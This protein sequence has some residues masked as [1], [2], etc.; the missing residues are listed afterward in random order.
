MSW[1]RGSLG[2]MVDAL[3][4]EGSGRCDVRTGAVALSAEPGIDATSPDLETAKAQTPTITQTTTI[5]KSRWR[6]LMV[7]QLTW[8]TAPLTRR[9][10]WVLDW[11]V[12]DRFSPHLGRAE[13]S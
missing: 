11:L 8:H 6:L 10:H 5:T 12:F 7:H 13:S 3:G 2:V 9:F 4:C 1:T